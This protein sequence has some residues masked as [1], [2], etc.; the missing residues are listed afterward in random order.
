MPKVLQK[1]QEFRKDLHVLVW[2]EDDLFVAKCLE[3]EV[4]SQGETSAK[5]VKN[6]REAIE[7]YF[8][9]EPKLRFTPLSNPRLTT[10]S[11]A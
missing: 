2:R 3:V 7:L 9:D 4:V 5:A 1:L 6:L 10:I 8:E 11:Y